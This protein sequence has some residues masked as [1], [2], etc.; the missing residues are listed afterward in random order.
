MLEY[1]NL[2]AD[3]K[4]RNGSGYSA[5]IPATEAICRKAASTRA[6]KPGLF[7]AKGVSISLEIPAASA[8]RKMRSR[9]SRNC[10]AATGSPKS[11][12]LTAHALFSSVH[13]GDRSSGVSSKV[14]F[15]CGI[16]LAFSR[17]GSSQRYNSQA[18]IS[19]NIN[20]DVKPPIEKSARYEARFSI[21]V[22]T[23]KIIF[24]GR[25]IESGSISEMQPARSEVQ[26][27][28]FLVPFKLPRHQSAPVSMTDSAQYHERNYLIKLYI[29]SKALWI[30][31]CAQ[32]LEYASEASA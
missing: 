23:I 10:D 7:G 30:T 25:P 12:T 6:S 1:S 24:G 14:F 19:Q 15:R 17:V 2:G 20:E 9:R 27:G 26:R 21:I 31:Y 3:L 8:A 13:S 5:A 18:I 29:F 32:H 22:T 11:A 28:F 4:L 16:L